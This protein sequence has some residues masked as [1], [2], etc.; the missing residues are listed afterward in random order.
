MGRGCTIFYCTHIFDHLEGWASH[1]LHLSQGQVVR[2]CAMSEIEEYKLLCKDGNL[3]PLYSL[4]RGW[5]YSDYEELGEKKSWREVDDKSLKD[6]R[7]PNFGLAGPF[8]TVSG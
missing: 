6:G 3:T 7:I 2:A 8:Q 5:M 4:I 1:I